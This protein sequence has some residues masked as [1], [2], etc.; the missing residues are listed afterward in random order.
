MWAESP[1]SWAEVWADPPLGSGRHLLRLLRSLPGNSQY[2]MHLLTLACERGQRVEVGECP[3]LKGG[4]YNL[5]KIGEN[6]FDPFA[7]KLG[8]FQAFP[9]PFLPPLPLGLPAFFSLGGG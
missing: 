9:L 4:G 8:R 3:A 2:P 1:G 5:V 7:L 6:W